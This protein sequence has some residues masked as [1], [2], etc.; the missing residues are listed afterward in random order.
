[1]LQVG[2][3]AIYSGANL[4]PL[5]FFS[6]K[7]KTYSSLSVQSGLTSVSQAHIYTLIKLQKQTQL[8]YYSTLL[9]PPEYPSTKTHTCFKEEM[10]EVEDLRGHGQSL[11]RPQLA[12]SIAFVIIA[13]S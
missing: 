1:M 2:L 12:R 9:P 6:R 8:K 10:K 4:E 5:K 7:L 13:I 11:L 3:C